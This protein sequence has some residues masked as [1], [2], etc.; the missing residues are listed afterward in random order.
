MAD[1][2]AKLLERVQS[3]TGADQRLDS[4]IAY[5]FGC[6]ACEQ[7]DPPAYTSS[8]DLCVSLI[9]R[10]IPGWHWHVGFG[11]KGVMPYASLYTDQLHYEAM[12]GTV[13]L[14]LLSALLQAQSAVAKGSVGTQ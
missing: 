14:A 13:P 1:R 11:P 2:F 7:D 3:A 9:E 10:V 6:V 12:A 8:I 4:E 5:F